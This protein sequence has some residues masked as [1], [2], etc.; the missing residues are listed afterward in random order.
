MGG[1]PG[2]SLLHPEGL[3]WAAAAAGLL[4]VPP[5]MGYGR[6]LAPWGVPVFPTTDV[7]VPDSCGILPTLTTWG[8]LHPGELC[9]VAKGGWVGVLAF[10]GGKQGAAVLPPA[11]QEVLGRPGWGQSPAPQGCAGT[12]AG[13]M[14]GAL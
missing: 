1:R 14:Q 9:P 5:A 7:G 2:R 12:H 8:S 13:I 10:P 6:V 11:P 3:R 4:A